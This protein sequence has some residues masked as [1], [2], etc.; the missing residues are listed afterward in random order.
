MQGDRRQVLQGPGG[1]RL[2][3]RLRERL[4]IDCS[5]SGDQPPVCLPFVAA[6]RILRVADA[7]PQCADDAAPLRTRGLRV[8]C[9]RV[10]VRSDRLQVLH[11]PCSASAF[12]VG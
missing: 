9:A 6:R 8:A 4:R 3:A 5:Y 1:L 12:G 10:R 2:A 7:V 11:D